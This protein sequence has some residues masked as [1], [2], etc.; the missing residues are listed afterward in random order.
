MDLGDAMT[1]I[2]E[3]AERQGFLARQTK[4]ATW[5]FRKG[6]NNWFFNVKDPGDILTVV[7]TLTGVGFDAAPLQGD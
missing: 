5:H 3:E 2:A 4:V 6:Q 7:A 1:L